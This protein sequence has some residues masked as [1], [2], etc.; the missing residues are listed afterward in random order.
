M[1][2]RIVVPTLERDEETLVIPAGTQTGSTFRI[3][4]RG[5][6]KRGGSARGDLY[7]TVNVVVPSKL[8]KEQ[9]ELLTKLAETIET[10]NK[11][12][13]RKILERVKEIFS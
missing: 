4:G 1:G 12:I 2:D 10:E 13:Q 6:S 5:V 7:V 11:P 9:K 8:T 3:K